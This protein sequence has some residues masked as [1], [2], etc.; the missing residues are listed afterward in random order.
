MMA[1][2]IYHYNMHAE[3]RY[4]LGRE[5]RVLYNLIALNGNIVSYS[6]SGVA[7]FIST[8]AR[9][10]FID[11]Q[12]YAF[13]HDTIN[14]KRDESD[15]DVGVLP[16][17]QFK[18][19]IIKLANDRLKGLFGLVI[20]NDKPIT[21]DD[22]YDNNIID[23]NIIG[24]TCENVINF[25]LNI[26]IESLDNETKEFLNSTIDFKPEF[27]IAPYFSLS[28][29]NFKKW[30]E[31]NLH[32]YSIS[33][34]IY[35]YLNVFFALVVSK[36]ILYNN[37]E[38]ILEKI[39]EL[40]PQGILLWIDENIEENLFD[41]EVEDYYQFLKKLKDSTEVL[42]NSHGGYLSI[43]LCHE[44]IGPILDGVGHSINY[45]ESRPIIP[46]G[47]GIPMAR[48]YFQSIHS[49]LRFGD[50]LR[51]NIS[52]G[53]LNSED[54]YRQ[55]VCKCQQCM[56]LLKKLHDIKSTFNAYG[57]SNP[58]TFR[59]RPGTI[60]QLEYPTGAAK[61]AAARHYLYNKA[62]EFKSLKEKSFDELLENL[63]YTYNDI[64]TSV[65]RELIEHLNN[66]H[67]GLS[68]I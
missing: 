6:P 17:Y 37:K 26:L 59:R 12:T 68:N 2:H 18:P 25:Q 3:Q 63:K 65:G 36:K 46:V 23:N 62:L 5:H 19:S 15:K 30:L 13:Q 10:Y 20:K 27:V 51:I 66:W 39:D 45:G 56:D 4:F 61:Q 29:L 24:E 44:E 54:S 22:F 21:P 31:I 38:Y 50:A 7:G 32:L 67:S 28:D 49:R 16:D 41:Y 52:K 8:A 53:W 43:L 55:Y 35:N 40:K 58:V 47:G 48:F 1:I 9:K 57:E 34:E 11:P 14:L 64:A 42:Y 33:R 60:V